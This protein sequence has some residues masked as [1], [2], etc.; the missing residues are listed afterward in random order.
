[1]ILRPHESAN[2]AVGHNKCLPYFLRH[3]VVPHCAFSSNLFHGQIAQIHFV[4]NWAGLKPRRSPNKGVRPRTLK[5]ISTI[6]VDE[7]MKNVALEKFLKEPPSNPATFEQE[8]PLKPGGETVSTLHCPKLTFQH[9][10]NFCRK[11]FP[12]LTKR[13]LHIFIQFLGL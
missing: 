3:S 6:W 8:R 10:S 2:D 5:Y 4:F 1:M 13:L 7:K 11:K 9:F 12:D